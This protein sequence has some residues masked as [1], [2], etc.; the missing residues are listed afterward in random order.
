[1]PHRNRARTCHPVVVG[2]RGLASIAWRGAGFGGGGAR[3]PRRDDRSSDAEPAPVSRDTSPVAAHGV[4][5]VS[6]MRRTIRKPTPSRLTC[7]RRP[8]KRAGVFDAGASKR[9]VCHS[10][11]RSIG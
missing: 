8:K 5:A 2:S 4:L 10:V 11:G 6:Q 9:A 1:M 3:R 7:G